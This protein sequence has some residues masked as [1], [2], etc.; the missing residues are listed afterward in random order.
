M[1]DGLMV[2]VHSSHTIP[3]AAILSNPI[4][5]PTG[6]GVAIAVKES[7]IDR[8]EVRNAGIINS[9]ISGDIGESCVS[10][11]EDPVGELALEMGVPG[12]SKVNCNLFFLAALY[13][14]CDLMSLWGMTGPRGDNLTFD[15][16]REPDL[17]M[18]KK[19]PKAACTPNLIFE[20]LSTINDSYLVWVSE[21]LI[22]SKLQWTP[23]NE[24]R[25]TNPAI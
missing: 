8:S 13:S 19:I 23:L 2:A 20:S 1:G 17:E 10:V 18:F 11:E 14:K 9:Y 15:F 21:V 24:P 7:R 16:G 25:I 22:Q 5:I 6:Q 4:G 3:Y 12:W